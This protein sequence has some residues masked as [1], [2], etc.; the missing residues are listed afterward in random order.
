MRLR[1][2]S[3][4]LVA[5]LFVAASPANKLNAQTTTSGGLTG[6]VTDPSHALVP[7][8][9]VEIKDTAK[10]TT[11]STKT[12]REGVYEFSFLAPERYTLTVTHEG[13]RK[14]SRVVTVPLGPPVT[15]NVTLKLAAERTIVNVTGV[16]PLIQADNGDFS[17]VRAAPG[18]FEEGRAES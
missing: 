13:F 3:V 11:Q 6:V 16:A 14:E 2:I 18:I 1:P 5:A 15:A 17:R 10:G 8:A 4:L 12:D 7:D 9:D